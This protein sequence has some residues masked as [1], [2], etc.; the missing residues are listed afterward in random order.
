MATPNV[1]VRS[2]NRILVHLDGQQIGLIQSLRMNDD[3]GPEPASGIGDIHVQEYV[4]TIAR[5]TLQVASM[6]ISRDGLRARGIASENGDAAL[7]GLE[8]DVLVQDRDTGEVLRKYV[9]VTY[10]SGDVEVQ[11]H[12]IAM[13][14]ATLMARDVQG[15]GA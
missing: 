12:A 2:G 13:A 1:R 4:P 6:I 9:G 8:F 7:R 10:A 11:K 5:H 3:Y 15:L 14:N